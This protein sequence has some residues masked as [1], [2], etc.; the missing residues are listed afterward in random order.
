MVL[1]RLPFT[2]MGRRLA[3][4]SRARA[5]SGMAQPQNAMPAAPTAAPARARKFLRV[6]MADVSLSVFVS[7]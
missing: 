3:S 1:T 2:V 6:V 4:G 7:A 5:A